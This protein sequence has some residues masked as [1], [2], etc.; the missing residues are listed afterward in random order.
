MKASQTI[1]IPPLPEGAPGR[2]K[3][4]RYREQ[5][6]V[7]LICEGAEAQKR[8]FETLVELGFKPRVVVT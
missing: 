6:G 5:Y 7:I 2:P 8:I 4:D 1:P 3:D